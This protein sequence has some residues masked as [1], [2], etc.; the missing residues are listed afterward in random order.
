MEFLELL[1][2]KADDVVRDA[3]AE[4]RQARLE[5]YEGEGA[6]VARERLSLLLELTLS[7]L[8]ARQAE[9]MIECATRIG[10]ERFE[11][12][13]GLLEVQTAFNTLEEA[14]WKRILSSVSKEDFPHALGLTSAILGMGKDALA[15]TYVSLASG[16][17]FEPLRIENFLRGSED[18]QGVREGGADTG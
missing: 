8:E 1:R 7:C 13:Y 5:H 15:R 18:A 9:P 4:L 11:A 3:L 17:E 12:G 14:L 10:R 6:Q 2:E 16:G